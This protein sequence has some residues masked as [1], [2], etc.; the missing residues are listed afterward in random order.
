MLAIETHGL[1][2]TFGERTAVEDLSLSIP[3]GSVFGFLGP[4]GA[5]KTT[6]VRML[7]ALIAPTRGEAVV[8]GHRLGPDNDAIRRSVGILTESPGL[9]DRLT[10][11]QNLEFFARLY[12]V[13]PGRASAQTERYLRELDLWE[14]RDDKVGGFSK[15]MRQKLAIARALLHEPQLIFLDEPTSGLD[16]E[17]AR[18]ILNDIKTMKSAGRTIFLT[19]HNLPEADELCDQ[20]GVFRTRMLRMD[21][22]D[23]LRSELFGRGVIVRVNG[24]AV[25]YQ[26]AAQS[27]SFVRGV[28]AND[29]A[30]SIQMDDPDQQSPLLVQALI[31]AGAQIRSVEP[32]AHSLEEVYMKLVG[33]SR[34]EVKS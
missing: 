28:A 33:S 14:R 18:L 34:E 15:G 12:D 5:G 3:A 25:Q 19:T 26:A 11:R 24:E 1:T 31:T 20:I 17:A 29:G 2:R 10:A 32:M 4:N 23:H 22:P 6:T 13:E 9:Y 21:T 27:L 16:P 7:A 8:L 30:L